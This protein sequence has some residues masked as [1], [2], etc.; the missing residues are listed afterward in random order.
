VDLKLAWSVDGADLVL[1]KGDLSVD[2]GLVPAVLVSLFSE[3]LA[4][5]D[6]EVPAT[7][8]DRRGYWA[9]VEGDSYGSLLWTLR[10]AKATAATQARAREMVLES[11]A[12]MQRDALVR[13][14]VV[15]TRYLAS[16]V[17]AVSITLTRGTAR[18]WG[19]LWD[20]TEALS[21]TTEG[22]LLQVAAT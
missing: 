3:A 12:W 18:R 17:L 22:L 1:A 19:A 13:S 8:Q 2:E 15:D 20:A 9:Q 4:P 14:V 6:Q 7:Q 21:L 5:L 16:G 11:L 10:R